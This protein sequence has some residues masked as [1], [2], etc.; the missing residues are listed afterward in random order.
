MMT[1]KHFST[2]MRMLG[3]SIGGIYAIEMTGEKLSSVNI[4]STYA[5]FFA[6]VR[7]ESGQAEYLINS[8]RY[9]LKTGTIMVLSPRQLVLIEKFS[10][11]YSATYIAIEPPLFEKVLTKSVDSKAL[12]DRLI[13]GHLPFVD[14]DESHSALA[15]DI[16]Q[17]LMNLQQSKGIV[18][19]NP[20]RPI[21]S[22]R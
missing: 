4:E 11:D 22:T 15:A 20:Y 3:E 9:E 17:L 16:M 8:R 21:C 12:A 5:D 2:Q 1:I 13:M 18:C 19:A 7:V 10:A 6:F 14:D